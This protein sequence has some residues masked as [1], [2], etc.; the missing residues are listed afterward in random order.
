MATQKDP[1]VDPFAKWALHVLSIFRRMCLHQKPQA[2]QVLKKFV[3]VQ[4]PASSA[5]SGFHRVLSFLLHQVRWGIQDPDSC[6][7]STPNGTIRLDFCNTE[8]FKLQLALSLR[9]YLLQQIPPRHDTGDIPVGYQCDI[10]LT[11]Y[12]I[13]T[14]ANRA[15]EIRQLMPSLQKLPPNVSYAKRLLSY[16]Q[17]GKVFTGVRLFAA[18]MRESD[19][20]PFCGERETHDHVFKFCHAYDDTRPTLPAHTPDFTW[21][22]GIMFTPAIQFEDP[23]FFDVLQQNS[24]SPVFAFDVVFSDGSLFQHEYGRISAAASAVFLHGTIEWAM[25]L[26]GSEQTTPRAEAFAIAMALVCTKGDITIASDC[27]EVIRTFRKLFEQNFSPEA[28]AKVA[29]RDIWQCIARL[30][31]V[32][33]KIQIIKVKAHLGFDDPRQSSFL[34]RGN[35]AAD[36]LA[37]KC[38]FAKFSSLVPTMEPWFIDAVKL[39]CHVVSSLVRRKDQ[40]ALIPGWDDADLLPPCTL[41]SS[42]TCVCSPHHRV[43]GKK[44]CCMGCKSLPTFGNLESRFVH[45]CEAGA[46]SD[47]LLNAVLANYE[48]FQ[49]RTFAD[50]S[51]NP[52]VPSLDT[53]QTVLKRS[54]PPKGLPDLISF[55]QHARFCI[56][57][58][59]GGDRVPWMV[60]FLDFCAAF[61][62]SDLIHSCSSLHNA[63]CH[64]KTQLCKAYKSI[65]ISFLSSR[66]CTNLSDF[67]FAALSGFFGAYKPSNPVGFWYFVVKFFL[68]HAAGDK[69]SLDLLHRSPFPPEAN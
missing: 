12:L 8:R 63:V 55:L 15:P 16:A 11:R 20:C 26:P 57:E 28:L 67:G 44:T 42:Q 3:R 56:S 66:R 53:F 10:D 50:L 62:K 43:R 49:Q 30:T 46:V 31:T 64:F 69:P 29:N 22:T 4:T 5:V 25:P 48:V 61:P 19:E 37:K 52:S 39:Q 38:A 14:K 65:G 36:S 1:F 2:V 45:D 35:H 58:N 47:Q 32:D 7:F 24:P 60:V 9:T 27:L 51:P 33:R 68:C 23:Q 54:P 41:S 17:H 21:R 6:C 13:D 34:T 59:E 18:G 40:F